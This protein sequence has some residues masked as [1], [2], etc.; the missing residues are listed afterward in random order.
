MTIFQI[1]MMGLWIGIIT[2]HLLDCWVEGGS[3][4]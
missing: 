1:I 4:I 2:L 3:C